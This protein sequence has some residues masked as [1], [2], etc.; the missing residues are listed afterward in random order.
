MLPQWNDNDV[1]VLV[2]RHWDRFPV[3]FI[4][5]V[6]A[7]RLLGGHPA[8][9]LHGGGNTSCKTNWTD[10]VGEEIQTLFV[11]ASG[12]D[13]AVVEPGDFV[14]LDLDRLR[15]LEQVENISD[16]MMDDLFRLS[17]VRNH[18]AQPSIETLL[19]A[20]LP[21]TFITH[22]HPSAI[23]ALANRHDAAE[24]IRSAFTV[25]VAILSYV[26]VGI[27]LAR[28]VAGAVAAMPECR[29][30]IIAH[31][32]L[33]TWGESAHEACTSTLSLVKEAGD[34]L[35]NRRVAGNIIETS[36]KQAR[37]H[38]RVLAPVIR[39]RLMRG[40][41]SET[42]RARVSLVH[43]ADDRILSLLEHREFAASLVSAPHSPDYIIRIRR[44]P[45]FLENVSFENK[46][47]LTELLDKALE[48]YDK[49][50]REFFRKNNTETSDF[51]AE[52][53]D[54]LPRVF[55][56]PGIG[57]IA[58]GATLHDARIAADLAVQGV[59]VKADVFETGGRYLDLDDDHCFNME[60][61]PYQR[62]KLSNAVK[63]DQTLHGRIV[64]VTGAA[65]AIGSGLC[66]MLLR[67]GLQVAVSDLAG[68]RLDSL[69]NELSSLF[70]DDVIMPVPMDVTDEQSMYK[71]F[72]SVVER[73]GGIDAVVVNAGIAH[74]S[75]IAAMDFAAFK[76]LERVNTDGTLLTIR[77]AARLFMRQECG[78][79][80]VLVSTKNVFAPGA[81]FGAYS[82][83]KAASHQLARI[84]SLELASIDVR[85]NMVAPDAVFSH[86]SHKSG[87][88]ATVGPDRMRSRG[89]DEKGLEDY[90]HS[91]NLLKSKVT[92]SDVAEA[93]LFFLRRSTPTTGATIPVDGGLPDATPR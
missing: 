49:E 56:I 75:T 34:W 8:L 26:Q 9:T 32:G 54:T 4:E 47:L 53:V 68:E 64:L 77:E 31:H 25:P 36:V 27:D 50:Y 3:P 51:P 89:L 85:V 93:V 62:A 22:T 69:V 76:R 88:W 19:H 84:A 58:S 78:G 14:P 30:V 52:T 1:Q 90:Y 65:G 45:L 87:L 44:S 20:F 37:H 33:V 2:T 15:R 81:S 67:S 18:G 7:T 5:Q 41:S 40:L 92:A 60:C 59:N 10:P 13:M 57:I 70:G 61:R 72:M 79:D 73:F 6:Y 11:K 71:G 82:A 29:G 86:G 66:T 63:K 42:A 46:E 24:C 91:R 48:T 17:Y 39:G 83:T 38:F 55:L 23:L 21:F 16:V 28:A 74:V 43:R 80:I 12:C 35:D